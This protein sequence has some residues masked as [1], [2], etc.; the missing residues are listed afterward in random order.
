MTHN[1]SYSNAIATKTN[2]CYTS[3]VGLHLTYWVK[4]K[5]RSKIKRRCGGAALQMILALVLTLPRIVPGG[6]IKIFDMEYNISIYQ[7]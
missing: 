5:A 4:V 2:C 3:G 1:I 6:M 7:L